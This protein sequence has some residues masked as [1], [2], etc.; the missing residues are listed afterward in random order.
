M[1]SQIDH[2]LLDQIREP[3]N[4]RLSDGS[5]ENLLDFA[6]GPGAVCLTNNSA[7]EVLFVG[8]SH[9]MSINSAAHL[10]KYQSNPC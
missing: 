5:C 2:H 10:G 7:P 8:D 3:L 1:L 9:A 4:T 6:I